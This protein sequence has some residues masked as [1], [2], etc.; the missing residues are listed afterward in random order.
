ALFHCCMNRKQGLAEVLLKAG[1]DPN[2]RNRAGE[3]ALHAAVFRDDGQLVRLLLN[4]GAQVN[5]G[6]RH[7]KTP[8]DISGDGSVIRDLLAPL[9]RATE[10]PIPTAEAVLE[11]LRSMPEF[12]SVTLRGCTDAEITRLEEHFRVR[13][14]TAYREFLRR[15]G[16][17]AGEFM[18]SD[19]WRFQFDDL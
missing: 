1:A 10:C 18:E 8:Y 5:L 15:M 16:K 2:V 19:H 12:R 4:H 17:G 6:N 3:T 11:R 14:P 9:H 13:L 7:R